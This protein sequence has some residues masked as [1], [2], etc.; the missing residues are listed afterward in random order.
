MLKRSLQCAVLAAFVVLLAGCASVPSP[1]P[2]RTLN[3][4]NK[5]CRVQVS[6]TCHLYIFCHVSVDVDEVHAHGNNVFGDLKDEPDGKRFTFDPTTGIEFKT[7]EG[8]KTFDC[9]PVAGMRSYKC[10]NAKAIGRFEY[11][12]KVVGPVFVPR[13][14]PWVVN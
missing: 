10:N 7:P 11:G 5:E 8:K 6:V 14:D 4:S 1:S 2:P 13:L 3:C 12:V 9:Q